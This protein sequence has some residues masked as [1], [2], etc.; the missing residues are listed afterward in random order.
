MRDCEI[1]VEG[2]R[3]SGKGELWKDMSRREEGN[4]SDC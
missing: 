4:C 2:K 1:R 3:R